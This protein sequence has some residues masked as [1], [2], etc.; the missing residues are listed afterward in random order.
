MNDKAKAFCAEVQAL[1]RQH[2]VGSIEAVGPHGNNELVITYDLLDDSD[3]L[4]LVQI[5]PGN[6]LW[7]PGPG[8]G[9][10]P[11][12][13]R[14]RPFIDGLRSVMKKHGVQRIQSI[15]IS[16]ANQGI[17]FI[18]EFNDQNHFE[19]AAIT[20]TEIREP[21]EPGTRD[22]STVLATWTMKTGPAKGQPT[23]TQTWTYTQ[24]DHDAD[25]AGAGDPGGEVPDFVTP[26]SPPHNIFTRRQ[27]DAWYMAFMQPH[28]GV[29][30]WVQLE[31]VWQ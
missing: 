26:M 1:L 21:P 5:G 28:P 11:L 3:D 12:T 16:A 27:W 10:A 30:N 8:D 9:N 7:V 22:T 14:Q 19:I 29:T 20:Q 17:A 4:M 6:E 13:S 15:A 25:I 24:A 23:R 18:V 2:N 31:F